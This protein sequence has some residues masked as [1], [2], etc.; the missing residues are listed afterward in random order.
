MLSFMLSGL[1]IVFAF[2]GSF[3]YTPLMDT[4]LSA[5]TTPAAPR[6]VI[7]SDQWVSGETGPPAVS[8][9]KGYN[10][11]ALAFWLVSGPADQAEEWASLDNATRASIKKSY[12]AANISLIVSAFGSTDAPTSSGYD[13][14]T[15]ANDLAAFVLKYN[16]DGVDVDYEDFNAMNAQNGSAE[17]WLTTFTKALRAKLPKGQYILSHAPVAPWFSSTYSSGAYLKVNKNVGSL[18][19]WYNVQASIPRYMFYNQGKTEYTTCTGLLTKSSST[20]SNT[21]VFQIAAAGVS[22]DKLVIGKP[23]T[24]S[25]ASNGYMNTTLLAQCVEKAYKKGWDA[26]VMVWEFPDAA[27]AWIKAVRS[28]A[29]PE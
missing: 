3:F 24:K 12:H 26:G 23:A 7:Y 20:W 19:D 17:K 25:D 27:A 18:I 9:I 28:L 14:T 15:V 4:T 10:V 1:A 22:L 6:F 13:P 11:F 2:I 21:S 29:F 16:L 5:H 8:K